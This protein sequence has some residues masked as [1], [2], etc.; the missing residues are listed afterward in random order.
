MQKRYITFSLIFATLFVSIHFYNKKIR[1]EK[2]NDPDVIFDKETGYLWQNQLEKDKVL[3]LHTNGITYLKSLN[4]DDANNYCQSLI[5]DGITN[6][7]LPSEKELYRS[8]QIGTKFKNNNRW[9]FWSS[10]QIPENN[11]IAGCV[12]FDAR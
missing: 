10:T 11:K 12:N 4:W 1:L 2:A 8:Y 9:L 3:S 5:I 6:W 7:T